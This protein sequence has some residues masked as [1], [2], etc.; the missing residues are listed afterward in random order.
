MQLFR[1]R[2]FFHTFCADPVALHYP[3]VLSFVTSNP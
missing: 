3:C 2:N 1:N